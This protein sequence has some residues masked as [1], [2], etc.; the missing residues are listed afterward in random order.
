ME[1]EELPI[2]LTPRK[3]IKIVAVLSLILFFFVLFMALTISIVVEGPVGWYMSSDIVHTTYSIATR[4]GSATGYHYHYQL[5]DGNYAQIHFLIVLC[6]GTL[7]YLGL[8]IAIAKVMKLKEIL[9]NSR[10]RNEEQP[11]FNLVT[12]LVLIIAISPYFIFRQPEVRELVF[13]GEKPL[14][15]VHSQEYI[16]RY[17]K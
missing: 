6:L 3:S 12:T 16:E 8:T 9:T 17:W 11:K 14:S 10:G 5:D 2:N 4:T 15:A 7:F 13:N 1:S